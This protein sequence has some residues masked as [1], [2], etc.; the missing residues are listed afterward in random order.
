MNKRESAYAVAQQVDA[1]I[2]HNLAEHAITARNAT[3][4]LLFVRT[5]RTSLDQL[6]ALAN[7]RLHE[8]KV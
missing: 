6:E 4:W 5:I 8:K 7:N 3:N 2:N 1:I